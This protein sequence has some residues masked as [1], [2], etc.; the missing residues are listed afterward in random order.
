MSSYSRDLLGGVKVAGFASPFT[1]DPSPWDEKDF[2]LV[3]LELLLVALLK[4]IRSGG[5]EA[6]S[7]SLD[8]AVV[9]ALDALHKGREEIFRLLP[10]P[11]IHLARIDKVAAEIDI[12]RTRLTERL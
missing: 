7:N 10:D 11:E 3:A 8:D 6:A 9:R 1:D 2:R 4:G 5:T 12:I